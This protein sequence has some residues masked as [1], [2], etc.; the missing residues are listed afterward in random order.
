MSEIPIIYVL[1]IYIINTR[2]G[3]K[4][5]TKHVIFT[6]LNEYKLIAIILKEE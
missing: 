5:I 4:N 3:E 6:S 1:D 2:R